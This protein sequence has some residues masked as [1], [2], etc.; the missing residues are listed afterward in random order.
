MTKDPRDTHC[1]VGRRPGMA[2][3]DSAAL[4][5]ATEN[6]PHIDV[7]TEDSVKMKDV[8]EV[9]GANGIYADLPVRKIPIVRYRGPQEL[10][11]QLKAD[12]EQKR[13]RKAAKRKPNLLPTKET[14]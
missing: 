8:L 1:V 14:L 6:L 10:Q 5:V 11:E 3:L 2:T 9:L 13:L 12:A 7:I 4:Q